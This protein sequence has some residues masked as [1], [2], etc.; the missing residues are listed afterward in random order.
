MTGAKSSLFV[1]L[2]LAAT[3]AAGTNFAHAQENAG[4]EFEK[5]VIA[6][7]NDIRP[8]QYIDENGDSAGYLIDL[9]KLWSQKAG[10][11]V[12]FLGSSWDQSVEN[13]RTGVADIH[14]G[15][16]YSEDRDIDFDF[17]NDLITLEFHFFHT[18]QI[19]NLDSVEQLTAFKI[20]V[21]S[22]DIMDEY[23]TANFPDA[24]IL[25]YR[26]Y[27]EL[28]EAVSR[29][30]LMVFLSEEDAALYQLATRD[31]LGEF[32][33]GTGQP[34]M[35]STAVGAVRDGAQALTEFINSGW[36]QISEAEKED[37]KRRWLGTFDVNDRREG[38]MVS[39]ARDYAPLSQI[40]YLGEPAGILIDIWTLWAEKHGL[41]VEFISRGGEE[42]VSYVLDGVADFHA[43][44]AK[45]GAAG[46]E[47]HYSRPVYRV[48]SNFFTRSGMESVDVDSVL[49]R[50][51]GVV[52]NGPQQAY[53]EGR[54]AGGETVAYRDLDSLVQGL[55]IGE[56][57]AVLGEEIVINELVQR[58]GLEG[59]IISLGSSAYSHEIYAATS[60]E[61]EHLLPVIDSGLEGISLSE[62]EEIETRWLT[63][64]TVVD[65][66]MVMI[67]G[68]TSL[69]FVIVIVGWGVQVR[70]K[71]KIIERGE[72]QLRHI[73]DNISAGIIISTSQGEVLYGNSG[74]TRLFGRPAHEIV[75]QKAA[76]FYVDE[77]QRIKA[78]EKLKRDGEL[79]DIELE[80]HKNNDETFWSMLSAVPIEY[81][82]RQAILTSHI[83]VTQRKKM[84][85][86][87]RAAKDVAQEAE[88]RSQNILDN[89]SVGAVITYPE[90]GEILYANSQFA[91]LFGTTVGEIVGRHGVDFYGSK[92]DRPKVVAEFIK[93]RRVVDYDV[94]FKRIDGSLFDGLLSMEHINFSGR[95]CIMSWIHDI[96][97]R[98]KMEEQLK[99]G[100]RR[101]RNILDSS[102]V[103]VAVAG[104]K[105]GKIV[106]ANGELGKLFDQ[107]AADFIGQDAGQFYTDLEV[108]SE[109][110]AEMAQK[111]F[112]DRKDMTFQRSDGSTFDGLISLG[113]VE[114][115]GS[116]ANIAW[117][118][119][120]SDRKRM[121][122]DLRS[123]K[124]AAEDAARAKSAFLAAMSHEIR[125]PMN[126][127]VGMVDLLS[128]TKLDG[129]QRQML[130]TVRDSGHSLLTIINDIL[131]FSK[132]EAG[133]LDIEAVDMSLVDVV[134][135]AAQTIAPN[136]V[137]KGVRLLTYV[138]P[139]ITQFL[140]GDPTRV[141]QII[142]N[143]GGNAIKFS[144]KGKEVVVRAE[145]V[146]NGDDGTARVRIR[147]VDQGIG[148][149]ED[150]QANLFQEFSQ[151]DVST[152]RKF[153]GTGLGLA[154]CKR[155]T[156]LMGGEIGVESVLGEGSTFWCELPFDV[157]DKTREER[158]VSDLSG[159]RI[160]V[161]SQSSAYREICR[162]YLAH[163]NAEIE[164][165]SDIDEC[166]QRSQDARK[167]G[168]PLD[169]ILI[170][171]LDDHTKVAATR[172]SFIDAGLM[173]Y[174]RF[175][176]GEDPRDKDELLK[177]IE[178]V[179][180]MDINPMR[181]AGMLSAVAIAAGRA[182]PEVH[183]Q[184]EV[185]VIKAGRTPTVEEALEQGKLILLAEDNLTNQ[186]VIRKQLNALGYQCEIAN[187][188]REAF[189]M[190][191]EKPYSI[192]LTDCHMPEWDG[193]ELTAAVRK[194]EES[195]DKRSPIIAITAN[196][197]QGEAERC[198]AAGMD[199]YMSKPVEMKIL[200]QTLVKWMGEGSISASSN[201]TSVTTSS[202]Q[203]SA[204]DTTDTKGNGSSPIDER[205]LKDMFGDDDEMFKEI[206]QGFI[207][208]T[209][210]ILKDIATALEARSAADI[211]GA[212]HKLKSSARSIGANELADTCLALENAG[213]DED[214]VTIDEQ[215][216]RVKP[217]FKDIKG[218]IETL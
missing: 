158:K 104:M 172:K 149:S 47:L 122:V 86:E 136:A 126:G 94:T 89:S 204:S 218:Y 12:E 5:L 101:F 201:D 49:T 121:E 1:N 58:R 179:T 100:E 8:T 206:L 99:E 27:E 124:D 30:D 102:S 160:L 163:W 51:I 61:N 53:L 109:V 119:D 144:D 141:R 202:S 107:E 10:V 57:D 43:G 207:E 159:L 87:I 213:L 23:A 214:W 205:M 130:S 123:A 69:A 113:I 85:D 90:T 98:K 18:K 64:E 52:R 44:I 29:G 32:S 16:V 88:K 105:S 2:I 150:A 75:G 217:L 181:R 72:A 73:L 178:E 139:S 25:R 93:N 154:I 28:M 188:G 112:V 21:I 166:L 127:V 45:D 189:E 95:D 132:I 42:S 145:K 108:R 40:N 211:K 26:G 146:G 162:D 110:L 24:N 167:A 138:D 180:M 177:D 6:H 67:V 135:G 156:E 19:V 128:Q 137:K 115:E 9:W 38:F 63:T 60:L 173:P 187:D 92:D 22:D 11:E 56:V 175:V 80:F 81:E 176:I 59:D 165:T 197:L 77:N 193:F 120:I 15:M 164:V 70:R 174:P 195:S 151:A 97:Q 62:I 55:M 74:V 198:I 76:E 170:P 186:L 142:I 84:V 192:L 155:L 125:T 116:P 82:G 35:T 33:Y 191:Q 140:K 157:S 153:G 171:D 78:I 194:R 103:A 65:Y 106:Y 183:H 184:E 41:K 169:I 147:V 143:M 118:Y 4:R 66:T 210:D 133:K 148:I 91:K 200:K 79:H 36:D 17:S 83:D 20:G 216:P 185:E 114:Y 134:E 199:D 50:R 48:D 212:A 161:V 7:A 46:K 71:S 117:I 96:T 129:D 39:F 196:A 215:A 111:G 34:F 208:P 182:S 203:P 152:T 190:W 68:G 3:F 13:L 168:E 131:D 31:R 37:Y 14:A 54:D 209:E